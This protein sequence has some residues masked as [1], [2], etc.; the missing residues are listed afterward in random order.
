LRGDA[1]DC[2]AINWQSEG[3]PGLKQ[4]ISALAPLTTQIPFA[5]AGIAQA[6]SMGGTLEKK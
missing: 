4:Q 1:G 2:V 6:L 3:I 5:R